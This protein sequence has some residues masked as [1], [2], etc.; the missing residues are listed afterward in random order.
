VYVTASGLDREESVTVIVRVSPVVTVPPILA[1][2]LALFCT[3]VLLEAR[4]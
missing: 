2:C 3:A 1:D 4:S